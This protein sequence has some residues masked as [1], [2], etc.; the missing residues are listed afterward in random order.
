MRYKK[1]HIPVLGEQLKIFKLLINGTSEF[2]EFVERIEKDGVFTNEITNIF[3]A[4]ER[5][6][7]NPALPRVAS[8]EQLK[9]DKKDPYIDY[10]I[11]TGN[12][13]VYG[14]KDE[15]II[16][17]MGNIK[18]KKTQDQDLKRFRKIK[19]EYFNWKNSKK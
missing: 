7:R 14:F 19:Y 13:R 6:A 10:K 4:I 2:D 3:G 17:V 1:E 12:L 15:G 11:F 16:L 8:W 5:K 9:R 18:S